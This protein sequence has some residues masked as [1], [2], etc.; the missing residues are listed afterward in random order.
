MIDEQL[1][2]KFKIFGVFDGC[3]SGKDSHFASSLLGKTVIS[4][5]KKV[6]FEQSVNP[7]KEIVYQAIRSYK[8]IQNSLKLDVNE[9]LS[10]MIL[11]LLN[12]ETNIAEIIAIGDGLVSVNQEITNIDQLNQPDY[13]AYHF[14]EIENYNDFEDFYTKQLIFSNIKVED[15]T[16]STDGINSYLI[17]GQNESQEIDVIEYFTKDSFLNGNPAMLARK[18][19]I[20]KNKHRLENGDDIA[21]IRITNFE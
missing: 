8:E 21:I 4:A 12:T 17:K 6:D 15:I 13:P 9:M 5:A 19:N 3:S 1:N 11:M 10:T 18:H 7:L 16:I 2:G 14:D 20:L